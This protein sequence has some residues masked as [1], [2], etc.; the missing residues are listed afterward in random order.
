MCAALRGVDPNSLSERA[1]V[2]SECPRVDPCTARVEQDEGL[3]L[4]M[5]LIPRVDAI[6]ARVL[7][8]GLTSH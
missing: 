7:R 3:S 1:K 6:Q 4:S 2:G 8:H 5:G